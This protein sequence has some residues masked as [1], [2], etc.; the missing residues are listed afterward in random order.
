MDPGSKETQLLPIRLLES[1]VQGHPASQRRP[2]RRSRG[3]AGS[4]VTQFFHPHLY[5]SHPTSNHHQINCKRMKMDCNPPP[6]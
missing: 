5:P 2:F 3:P 4:A 6:L 1:W